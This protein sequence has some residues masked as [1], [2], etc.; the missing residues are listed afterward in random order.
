MGDFS[1]YEILFV[2]NDLLGL[3]QQKMEELIIIKRFGSDI[4]LS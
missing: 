2:M 3:S 1:K 4:F